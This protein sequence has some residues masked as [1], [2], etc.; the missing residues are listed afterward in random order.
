M[1]TLKIAAAPRSILV[2]VGALRLQH[3]GPRTA[4]ERIDRYRDR[5]DHLG[6]LG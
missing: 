5:D 3:Q 2:D 6:A 1:N 4:R